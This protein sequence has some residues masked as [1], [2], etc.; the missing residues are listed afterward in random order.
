MVEFNKSWY[1]RL[2]SQTNEKEIL[3][4]R[5]A[6]LI[7]FKPCE[8]CLEI[9]LGLSPYFAERL[10]QNF[11]RY[12]IV[13]KEIIK[14]PL[15]EGVEVI[16]FN[17]E[18]LQIEEKFDVIIASHVIYYFNDKKKAIEKMLNRLNGGGRI[19]FVVN[20]KSADYG[21]LKR[22][23]SEMIGEKYQFTYD[24]LLDILEGKS[25]KEYTSPSK[26]NF[27]SYEELF[28]TLRLS[29][30]A[31]PSEYEKNKDKIIEYLRR[32]VRRENFIVDQKIIEVLK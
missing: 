23:F 22:A 7:R 6:D 2:I 8:S 25:I 32:N 9:G 17:W 12:L 28:E 11:K 26:I 3:V 15:P 18:D 5:I 21:P 16:N 19:V 10:S 27:N 20:G 4:S 13:E 24:E 14:A 30:D 31:Y 29:F 1:E